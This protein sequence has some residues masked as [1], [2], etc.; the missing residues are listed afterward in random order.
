MTKKIY[1]SGYI[2]IGNDENLNIRENDTKEFLL[3]IDETN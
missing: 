2:C 1:I 3:Q